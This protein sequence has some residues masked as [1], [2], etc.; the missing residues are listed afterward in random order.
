MSQKQLNQSVQTGP[1]TAAGKARSSK[2]AQKSALFS[3]GY[4]PH[5]DVEAKKSQFIQMTNQWGAHDPTRLTLLRTLE[6]AQLGLERQMQLEKLIVQGALADCDIS[7]EFARRSGLGVIDDSQIPLWF[8]EEPYDGPIKQTCPYLAQVIEEAY[9]LKAKFSDRLFAEI[10]E[11]FPALYGYVMHDQRPGVAFSSVISNQFKQNS[12]PMNLAGL[13]NQMI[14]KKKWHFLWADHGERYQKLIDAIRA[15]KALGAIDA[16][17]SARY[18]TS[19]Q[20]RIIRAIQALVAMD[21]F[22]AQKT[23]QSVQSLIPVLQNE[24][25]AAKTASVSPV[26]ETEP[27][28]DDSSRQD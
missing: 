25:V 24:M 3:Q 14:D 22:E 2:N 5:E 4:L 15:K 10:E 19:F 6:Q 1:K 18:A 23:A 7:R 13:I 12:I 28:K 27:T 8:F 11:R 9:E 17:K 21:Q 20:N 26:I 16:D